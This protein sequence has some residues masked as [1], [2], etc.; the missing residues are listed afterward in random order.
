MLAKRCP[1][2]TP[3]FRSVVLSL[4]ASRRRLTRAL[5]P[6]LPSGQAQGRAL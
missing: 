5:R 2:D 1:Q 6:A 3:A 4:A